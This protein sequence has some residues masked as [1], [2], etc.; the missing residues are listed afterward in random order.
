MA[1]EQ[2]MY[3]MVILFEHPL[4]EQ[5]FQENWQKFMGLAEKL[6]RLRREIVSRV[7]QT[8]HGTDGKQI[9]RIHEL[10]FDSKD[11]L[12]AAM[13]SPAGQ[14]TGQ[15]LQAFTLGRFVLL[16]AEHMEAEEKDFKKNT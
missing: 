12:D 14:L 2:S 1:Q 4:D 5:E 6:P 15:F 13:G 16:T 7:D 8:V 10:I 9:T 3:K 11:A